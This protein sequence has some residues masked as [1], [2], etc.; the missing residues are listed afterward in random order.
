MKSAAAQGQLLLSIGALLAAERERRGIPVEK[1]AKETRM[2]PQ[3]IRDMEADDL[4]HFTNPSYARMFII[5]YAKYLD[6]PM[7]TIRDHLPDRGEPGS[8][9]YQY[10]NAA[11]DEL[12]SL[13]RD[14][15]SRPLKRNLWLPIVGVALV[16]LLVAIG[17]TVN[18]L[19]TSGERIKAALDKP[20]PEPEIVVVRPDPTPVPANFE[21]LR[22]EAAPAIFDAAASLVDPATPPAPKPEAAPGAS[23][24][25]EDRAFLLG[26]SPEGKPAAVP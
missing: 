6:I 13:R 26:S 18:Y 22:P 24:S 2:R 3:R 8:E 1:A 17:F 25:D 15:V 16:A 21:N 12:P 7:Q 5:A 10:M 9:G 20:A 19:V 11:P 23:P 14:L 4:S